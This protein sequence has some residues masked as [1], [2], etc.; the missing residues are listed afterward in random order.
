MSFLDE[1]SNSSSSSAQ[2]HF[3]DSFI[4][5]DGEQ[6]DHDHHEQQQQQQQSSSFIGDSAPSPSAAADSVEP[7]E[8][9]EK[10]SPP[11]HHQPKKIEAGGD[12]GSVPDS[13]YDALLAISGVVKKCLH[14]SG[15]ELE[16][17][18]FKDIARKATEKVLPDWQS[19]HNAKPSLTVQEFLSAKRRDAI[20]ALVNKY[21]ARLP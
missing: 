18:L 20:S 2:Q 17:D 7:K 12:H 6:P 9:E 5:G 19:K 10:R 11:P 13:D 3:S 4:A 21:L 8:R 1:A 14:A 15:K 16:R